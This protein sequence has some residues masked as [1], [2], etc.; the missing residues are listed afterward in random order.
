MGCLATTKDKFAEILVVG[1]EDSSFGHS[2]GQD[3]LIVGLRHS[4]SYS[5]HIMSGTTQVLDYC[6]AGGLIYD[7]LQGRWHL[8]RSFEREY[9]LMGEHVGGVG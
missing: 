6:C 7:E 1:D 8:D 2:P 5:K 4:L 9:V 3:F